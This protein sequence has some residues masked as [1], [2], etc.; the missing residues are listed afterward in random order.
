MKPG[1]YGYFEV[2]RNLERTVLL[3]KTRQ[4]KIK[5]ELL[6]QPDFYF[7]LFYPGHHRTNI[8]R[9]AYDF[10]SETALLF[11]ERQPKFTFLPLHVRL[12]SGYR[13]SFPLVKRSPTPI[14]RRG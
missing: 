4:T 12:Y 6:M 11:A 5:P 3:T 10:I 14:Q 13:V 7:A 9:F 1:F 8:Q 2:T